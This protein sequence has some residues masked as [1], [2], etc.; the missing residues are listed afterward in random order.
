MVWEDIS[1][2]NTKTVQPKTIPVIEEQKKDIISDTDFEK[3]LMTSTEKEKIV[4]LLYGE[5]G[6]GKT[7]IPL[8][9]LS[10]EDIKA[11]MSCVVI[12]LDGGCIP[13]I[14]RYYSQLCVKNN[15]KPS[16]VYI[17]KNPLVQA[18][19][20]GDEC[21]DYKE[22]F[23][24]IRKM[25]RWTKENWEKK[26]LK[27]IVFDGLSTALK[28]AESQMRLEKSLDADGGVQLRFWLVRNKIFSETLEMIKGLPISS[29][30]I[31]HT[32]FIL[33]NDGEDSSLK[34]KT[35]AAVHQK[36]KCIKT[37]VGTKTILTAKIEKSKYNVKLEGK[38]IVFCEV[39][40]KE[41]TYSWN[42]NKVLEGFI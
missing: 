30:F 7:P 4:C 28:H 24:I 5:D 10:E 38:E 35:N 15:R 23:N 12:D 21:I 33:K 40:G 14:N 1:E 20:E 27:F 16:E 18:S 11:G 13:L 37:R 17:V 22:T 31:G 41:G 3:W 8:S 32:D 19:K 42:G 6:T 34:V 2:S 36:I 25:I 26:K 29:F 39:D 9:Y